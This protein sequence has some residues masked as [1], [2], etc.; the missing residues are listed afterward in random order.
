MTAFILGA[1]PPPSRSAEVRN[2]T[3]L[4]LFPS[5]SRAAMNRFARTDKLGRWCSRFAAET[6]YPMDK[7]E[8]W[9]RKALPGASETD[10]TQD[11]MYKS[12]PGLNGIKLAVGIDFVTIFR[13]ANQTTTSIE[14][15][16]C[17]K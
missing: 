1:T 6:S 4:P 8:A 12:Y 3:G 9:Y 5:L 15:F 17:G 16:N 11:E 7:V 13:V 10:L 2:L 14:L